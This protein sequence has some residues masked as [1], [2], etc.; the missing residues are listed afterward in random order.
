MKKP[1]CRYEAKNE[2]GIQKTDSQCRPRPHLALPVP[3]ENTR[4]IA[5]SRHPYE[6]TILTMR[7][8]L[9]KHGSSKFP[10]PILYSHGRS[11]IPIYERKTFAVPLELR[12]ARHWA[13]GVKEPDT[14]LI[15]AAPKISWK[16]NRRSGKKPNPS[17]KAVADRPEDHK[18][19]KIMAEMFVKVAA[20]FLTVTFVFC[21][22]SFAEL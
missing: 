9:G 4:H 8:P 2:N 14:A 19:L 16:R 20:N 10:L 12:V 6:L 3:I 11:T 13:L 7:S 22:F 15:N 21:L 1:N 17:A 5:I 18:I